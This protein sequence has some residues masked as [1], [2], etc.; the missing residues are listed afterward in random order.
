MTFA[1]AALAYARADGEQRFLGRLA[2][3][4]GD[5]LLSE[6]DQASIDAAAIML[7][8]NGTAATRNRQV[9][10]PMSAILKHAGV[11]KTLR[12]PKG[13]RS[14]PRPHW[15]R[16]E[17]AFALLASATAVDGRLGAL[18]TFLLY[19]G[20][21]LSEALRLRWDDVDL[22]RATALIRETKNGSPVTVHLPALA[23]STLAN[24]A[25]RRGSV[26]RLAKS[27][28]LY[29]LLAKAEKSAGLELPA[30]SAF[31]V[32]RHSH[33]TWRRLY[34]GADTTALTRTGLWKSREAA[35][36]Y[37]HVDVTEE[38]RKSDLLPTPK[39]AMGVRSIGKA[40]KI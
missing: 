1:S 27:G 26:F 40:R 24:L 23:L 18:L 20:V 17:Q 19:T 39:C 31:H 35:S 6:I 21:R 37:E 3:H 13:W 30:R 16:Q 28:R 34:T 38:S 11:E 29:A 15:L 14:Q 4:F 2:D 32:L 9:Y 33:A 5:K 22:Q 7:Y 36:V 10:S 8:P 12:R 25:E